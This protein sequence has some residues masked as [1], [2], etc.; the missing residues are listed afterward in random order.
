MTNIVTA[1][2]LATNSLDVTSPSNME[3]DRIDTVTEWHVFN[4]DHGQRHYSMSNAVSVTEY[5]THLVR[6]WKES[7][8]SPDRLP[9]PPQGP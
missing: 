1:I 5:K 4:Y 8:P 6:E 9:R 7:P 3:M 2:V